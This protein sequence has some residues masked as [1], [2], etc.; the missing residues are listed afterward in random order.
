MAKY[1]QVSKVYRLPQLSARSTEGHG[2]EG[3]VRVELYGTESPA[4]EA[5]KLALGYLVGTAPTFGWGCALTLPLLHACPCTSCNCG[6]ALRWVL[7]LC[8][9]RFTACNFGSLCAR[10]ISQLSIL[11]LYH[12]FVFPTPASICQPLCR[13]RGREPGLLVGTVVL[14]WQN[15]IGSTVAELHLLASSSFSLLNRQPFFSGI[16][17]PRPHNLQM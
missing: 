8:A 12:C 1:K 5:G 2:A 3:L 4:K 16:S 7:V 17:A 11:Q 10:C 13:L 14:A 15:I 9:H 6:S